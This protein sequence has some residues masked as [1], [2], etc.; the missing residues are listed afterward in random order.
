MANTNY[1]ILLNVEL[2][3]NEIKK[4]LNQ[5]E[6]ETKFKM[7]ADTDDAVNNVNNLTDSMETAQLT[8]NAANEVFRTTIDIITSLAE[9]VYELDA[10]IIEFQKVSELSGKELDNYVSKLSKVGQTVGRTGKPN[11]SEPVC[12]DGKVA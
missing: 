3:T 10:S 6:K 7:S 2:Q 11:R 4:Q 9:Q 5:L 12:Y 8:F 1:S